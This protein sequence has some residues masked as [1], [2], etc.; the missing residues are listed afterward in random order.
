MSGLPAIAAAD[1]S[2]FANTTPATPV[3]EASLTTERNLFE[4][5]AQQSM[6]NSLGNASSLANPSALAGQL[7]RHL[8]GIMERTNH[9]TDFIRNKGRSMDHKEGSGAGGSTPLEGPQIHAGPA[10][11]HLMPSEP[12]SQRAEAV[13]GVSDHEYDSVIEALTRTLQLAT[14]SQ[15]LVTGS[16]NVVKS[17]NT[18]MR[19]Q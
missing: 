16:S 13:G 3:K 11:E 4:Y 10:R 9:Q 7:S 15:A 18:L 6:A 17:M 8:R 14:E 2:G 5:L 1:A 19:G 12:G